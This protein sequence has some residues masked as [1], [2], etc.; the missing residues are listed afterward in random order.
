MKKI[1]TRRKFTLYGERK[2]Y[3]MVP[4]ILRSCGNVVR[5]LG[6]SPR[7]LLTRRAYGSMFHIVDIASEEVGWLGTAV[8][9]GNTF[10]IDEIFLFK[11]KVHATETDISTDGLAEV[12]HQLLSSRP[13]GM[14]VCDNLRFWGHSHVH[15]GTTASGPDEM[16]M[17]KLR[18]SE[19]PWF[20][21]GIF[22]KDGR[23]E[24][25][26]FFYDSGIRIDDVQWSIVEEVD[27][28]LREGI[29]AEIA[30]KVVSQ[31]IVPAH[32]FVSGPEGSGFG[33]LLGEIPALGMGGHPDD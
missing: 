12:G 15:M 31:P 14:E 30:K 16:Q 32:V 27:D 33:E 13:D 19:H 6:E 26:I 1:P 17:H 24:F 29:K 10:V 28:G 8:R 5:L 3:P 2:K 21:R 18:E 9:E 25:T 20:I 4:F 7:I 22:N 11:Q 23:A